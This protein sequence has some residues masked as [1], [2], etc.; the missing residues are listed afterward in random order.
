[1]KPEDLTAEQKEIKLPD[2]QFEAASGGTGESSPTNGEFTCPQ[3]WSTNVWYH[4]WGGYVECS[5][6]DCGCEWKIP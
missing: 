4:D 1:M 2:E 6:R 5:C 3:C